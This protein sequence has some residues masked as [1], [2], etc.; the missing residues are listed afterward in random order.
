MNM[1]AFVDRDTCIGCGLCE[2]ICPEVFK[3]GDE[4]VSEVIVDE[5][6]DSLLE[7]AKEA[8]EQC[9]VGAIKIE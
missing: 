7:S 8:E 2:S 6:P 3:M 4:G 1:K 9:P 5:I